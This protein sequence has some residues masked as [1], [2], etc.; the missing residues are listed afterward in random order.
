MLFEHVCSACMSSSACMLSM[1]FKHVCQHAAGLD[2]TYI[3]AT[4]TLHTY[5]TERVSAVCIFSM[6]VKHVSHHAASLEGFLKLV[7]NARQ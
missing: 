7:I 6:Y 4:H 2:S 5:T 1:Y 3:H